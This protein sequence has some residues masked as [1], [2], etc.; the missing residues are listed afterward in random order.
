MVYDIYALNEAYEE[1]QFD[2]FFF[3]KRIYQWDCDIII[4]K[5]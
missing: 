5:D 2:F 3:N 4:I 1:G